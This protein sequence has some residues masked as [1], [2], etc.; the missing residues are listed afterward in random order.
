MLNI[1]SG[2]GQRTYAPYPSP[3]HVYRIGEIKKFAVA[4]LAIRPKHTLKIDD[5]TSSLQILN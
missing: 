4:C 2:R 5:I 3:I 1:L